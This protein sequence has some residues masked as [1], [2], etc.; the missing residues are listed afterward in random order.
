MND[1]GN[2]LKELVESLY[3]EDS[4]ALIHRLLDALDAV[5]SAAGEPGRQALA[6]FCLSVKA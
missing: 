4:D 2:G 5:V 3:I 6:R 1:E